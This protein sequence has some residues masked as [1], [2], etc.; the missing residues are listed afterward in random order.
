MTAPGSLGF[1][2]GVGRNF[3]PGDEVHGHVE[4]PVA[5]E[6]AIHARIKANAR[7]TRSRKLAEAVKNDSLEFRVWLGVEGLPVEEAA[8]GMRL[9]EALKAADAAWKTTLDA[10]RARGG[11]NNEFNEEEKAVW[12]TWSDAGRALDKFNEAN[13]DRYNAAQRAFHKT[14]GSP[15]QF[16]RDAIVQWGGLTDNQLAFAR[17]AWAERT[18]KTS[19]RNAENEARKAS[20]PAWTEGRNRN[21]EVTVASVRQKEN[22]FGICYKAMCKLADGRLL[23]TSLPSAV[24]PSDANGIRGEDLLKGKKLHIGAVTVTPSDEDPSMGFG[25]RP[26]N[27]TVMEEPEAVTRK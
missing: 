8:E 22:D 15:P 5:Y 20:A 4:H 16:L 18:E 14:Y 3:K 11:K 10:Y 13:Q 1:L 17:K 12:Q 27:V 24:I 6:N 21:L 19:A 9:F 25:K 2:S 23:W 7:K 26:H